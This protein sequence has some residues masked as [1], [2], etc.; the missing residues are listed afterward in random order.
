LHIGE[1]I[2]YLFPPL[3][4]TEERNTGFKKI[5]DAIKPMVLHFL[6]LKR[7]KLIAILIPDY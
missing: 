6:N 1:K 7:M 3:H 5:L 4:L 2:S